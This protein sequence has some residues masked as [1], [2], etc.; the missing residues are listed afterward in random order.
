MIKM[1]L[2]AAVALSGMGSV[3]T[4]KPIEYFI[5][6]SNEKRKKDVKDKVLGYNK[7]KKLNKVKGKIK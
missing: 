3:V 5:N 4:M 1:S 7:L 6:G 2:I